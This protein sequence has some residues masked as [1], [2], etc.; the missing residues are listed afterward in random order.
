MVPR[1]LRPSVVVRHLGDG[2]R[3]LGRK[4]EFRF[5]LGFRLKWNFF[6][7]LGRLT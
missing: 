2:Q 1:S 4:F 5:E 7:E 6:V 3:K